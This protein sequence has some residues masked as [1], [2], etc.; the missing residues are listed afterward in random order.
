H[1][2]YACNIFGIECDQIMDE[3][4]IDIDIDI[5]VDMFATSKT[6]F[7]NLSKSV[8]KTINQSYYQGDIAEVTLNVNELKRRRRRRR[9]RREKVALFIRTH[10][11]FTLH[12]RRDKDMRELQKRQEEMEAIAARE[13]HEQEKR[14]KEKDFKQLKL[15]YDKQIQEC[16]EQFAI[17]LS[18][19]R[20]R[21]LRIVLYGPTGEGKSLLANRF[22]GDDS[23]EGEQGPFVPSDDVH[24]KT[25]DIKKELVPCSTRYKYPFTVID[26]PGCFD[27]AGRDRYHINHLVQFLR[28]IEFIHAIVLVKS[29]ASPRLSSIY[30]HMLQCLQDTFGRDIWKHVVIVVTR[31]DSFSSVHKYTTQ[32]RSALLQT[33]HLTEQ[34]APFPVVCLNLKGQYVQPLQ[35]LVNHILPTIPSFSCRQLRSPLD[36]LQ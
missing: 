10:A 31:V 11:R 34:E 2:L 14:E 20:E 9:R 5:G 32:L 26:Q 19:E 22:I 17:A 30:Q 13:R 25:Q 16:K 28:G 7:H 18:Q 36:K 35:Q 23:E 4:G 8:S 24:S 1:G 12:L 29:F 3:F 15:E 33:L 6:T 27:S 21:F